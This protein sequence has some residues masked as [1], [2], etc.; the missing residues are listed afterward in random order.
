M[1]TPTRQQT[2][3]EARRFIEAIGLRDAQVLQ[4]K[5][6]I[7]SAVAEEIFGCI[8]EY[9]DEGAIPS[10]APLE[11]AFDL[12]TQKRP[13]IDVYETNGKAL[14]MACVLFD[15]G[16]PGEAILHIEVSENNEKLDLH[17]KYI[18]S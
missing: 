16:R 2:Y 15:N 6:G 4:H 3:D 8:D 9:F 18:G 10:I 12:R 11:A 5:F 1:R 7:S 14:G 13:C 17:Y